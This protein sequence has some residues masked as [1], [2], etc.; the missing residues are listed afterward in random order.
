MTAMGRFR[1][2]TVFE[3]LTDGVGKQSCRRGSCYGEVSISVFNWMDQRSGKRKVNGQVDVT[4][5]Q[6]ATVKRWPF[7]EVLLEWFSLKRRKRCV[8]LCDC[9]KA[10]A[11]FSNNHKVENRTHLPALGV[12]CM[13]LL[14]L[15]IDV[16]DSLVNLCFLWLAREKLG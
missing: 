1:S 10:C 16:T 13:Y 14:W 12:F 5:R 11:T 8:S 6:G 2:I 3:W 7:L 15:L 9:F 4:R